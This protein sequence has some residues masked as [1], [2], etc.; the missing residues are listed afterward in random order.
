MLFQADA[1]KNNAMLVAMMLNVLTF[2][3]DTIDVVNSL[4]T[5]ERE[6]K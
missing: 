4:E 3:M 5:M 1:P 6:I 2:P